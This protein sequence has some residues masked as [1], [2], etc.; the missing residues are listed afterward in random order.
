MSGEDSLSSTS[1]TNYKA[2][3][4]HIEDSIRWDLVFGDLLI[5]KV[6]VELVFGIGI[7]VTARTVYAGGVARGEVV[8]VL[9]QEAG[10]P[11]I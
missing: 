8:F 3:L 11:A 2:L 4:V 5:Q 9:V 1:Y 6:K 7:S 10:N